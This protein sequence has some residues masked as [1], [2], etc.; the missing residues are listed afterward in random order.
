MSKALE[1]GA[2]LDAARVELAA[3]VKPTKKEWDIHIQSAQAALQALKIK[4]KYE[5]PTREFEARFLLLKN[6]M[7]ELSIYAFDNLRFQTELVNL[8]TDKAKTGKSTTDITK[9]IKDVQT[10]L[11]TIKKEPAKTNV[12]KVAG[13]RTT[14]DPKVAK[15]EAKKSGEKVLTIPDFGS[16]ATK[17]RN[18]I[19]KMIGGKPLRPFNMMGSGYAYMATQELEIEL[20]AL[21]ATKLHELF[22]KLNIKGERIPFTRDKR[23]EYKTGGV[24]IQVPSDQGHL[25]KAINDKKWRVK[26]VGAKNAKRSNLPLYD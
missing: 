24:R 17:A 21:Q 5:A 25:A 13:D 8:S 2:L 7:Y 3:K 23:L 4:F 9:S 15:K 19:K 20:T 18:W 26:I 16:S 1:I 14:R 6:N 12:G 10:F 11:K 22:A